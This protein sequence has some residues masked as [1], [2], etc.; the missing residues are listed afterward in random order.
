VQ[1]VY[2]IVDAPH[3]PLPAGGGHAGAPLRIVAAGDVG[4]VCSSHPDDARIA[5][6]EAALWRHEHVVEALLED[7]A[8]LP[9]RFGTAVRE[10]HELHDLLG[11]RREALASALEL[12]RGRREI[13]VRVLWDPPEPEATGAGATGSEYLLGRLA[14]ERAAQARAESLHAVLSEHAVMAK[15]RVLET[16]RLLLSGS[17]LVDQ[18]GIPLFLAA[19]D[20]LASA[21]GDVVMVCTGPWPAH[22]FGP[23]LEEQR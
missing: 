11:R 13:G 20:D 22:N 23:A 1:Y 10:E 16:P 18:D 19:A 8:V 3:R 7:R 14:V 5:P 9:V 6:D 2:A 15:H 4:A 21:S 12:V 17:Y